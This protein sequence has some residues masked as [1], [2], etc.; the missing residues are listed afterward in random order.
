MNSSLSRQLTARPASR[1]VDSVCLNHARLRWQNGAA[2]ATPT[3]RTTTRAKSRRLCRRRKRSGGARPSRDDPR[4]H[5]GTF[6]ERHG[7]ARH[8]NAWRRARRE[9]HRRPLLEARPQAARRRGH[10]S[11]S[12]Q[13]QEHTGASRI[14]GQSG[15]RRAQVRDG[16][17]RRAVLHRTG[18]RERRSG[19]RRLRRGVRGVEARRLRRVGLEGQNRFNGRR[20]PEECR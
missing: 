7:G 18:G 14:F 1:A 20:R 19:L 10:V 5:G 12:R 8:R 13:I 17:R 2:A 3:T 15:R 9:V 4:N 16:F 11:S 6:G